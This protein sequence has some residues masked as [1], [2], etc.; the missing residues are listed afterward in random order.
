MLGNISFNRFYNIDSE[1]RRMNPISKILCVIIFLILTFMSS[2]IEFNL[3]LVLIVLYI[4]CF[5]NIPIKVY[6]KI[7]FS[8][9]PFILFIFL[10]DIL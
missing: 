10:I 9:I 8:L 1:I 4:L 7:I 5:S 3:I 6:L 2:S